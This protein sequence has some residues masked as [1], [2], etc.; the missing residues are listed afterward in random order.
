[1]RNMFTAQQRI[2]VTGA[3]SGIGQAIALRCNALGATV[4]ASGRNAERLAEG[5][6]RA[7]DPSRWLCVE[8]DLLED[9]E[10]LPEWIRE[11]ARRHGKLW[12]L[13]HAAGDGLMDSLRTYDLATA[14]QHFDLSFHMPMLLAKGFCDR[15]CSEN[16]GA[17][18]FLTS[19]SAV[20]AEKGHMIYGAAKAAVA[21]AAKAISQEV[22]PRLRVHCLAPGIVDTPLEE[23]AEAYMG[24]SY[25]EEQLR[26]YPLGFGH[27]DDVAQ[28]AAFLLS[29]QARWITGQNFVLAGGR[30]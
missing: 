22:A 23:R 15:R 6:R 18:L 12:G 25:R 5:Q 21:A 27:P 28:M 7:A 30:Y 14:R 2:L 3:S 24:A 1:M 8:R 13:A 17:L 10:A 11:L 29:E 19:A 9:M 26:G 20:F 4:L 16:G